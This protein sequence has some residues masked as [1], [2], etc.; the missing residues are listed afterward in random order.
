MAR[1]IGQSRRRVPI[2]DHYMTLHRTSAVFPLNR[3][4]MLVA[5][6]CSWLVLCGT[7]SEVEQA[8]LI[9]SLG[10]SLRLI[11][12]CE[13]PHDAEIVREAFQARDDN[14][15]YTIFNIEGT[16]VRVFLRD[17]VSHQAT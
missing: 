2:R 11:A 16:H 8:R 14:H 7:E 9:G 17:A 13:N 3:P 1:G 6:N 12:L 15:T 10:P 5:M 4:C